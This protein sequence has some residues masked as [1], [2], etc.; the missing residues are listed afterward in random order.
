MKLRGITFSRLLWDASVKRYKA[1]NSEEI[2]HAHAQS[3]VLVSKQYLLK[4]VI[5][6]LRNIELEDHA[7]A[8]FTPNFAFL[9]ILQSILYRK[10]PQNWRFVFCG[11]I[12]GEKHKIP[13]DHIIMAL[14]HKMQCYG[15]FVHQSTLLEWHL[16][17]F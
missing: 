15:N 7:M 4:A 5:Q 9:F 11:Q 3:V 14:R 8:H 1:I 16:S 12:V 17:T 2:A 10:S 6:V 13:L